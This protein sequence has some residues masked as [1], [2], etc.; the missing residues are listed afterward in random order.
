VVSVSETPR[1]L[2][3]DNLIDIFRSYRSN[4]LL[5]TADSRLPHTDRARYDLTA[6]CTDFADFQT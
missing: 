4:K 2:L 3:G 1:D 6:T 5:P